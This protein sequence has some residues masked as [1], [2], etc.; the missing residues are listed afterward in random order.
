MKKAASAVLA[1]AMAASLL[2]VPASALTLEEARELLRTNY[3]DTIPEDILNLDSLDK[4]LEALG[5]PYTVYMTAE[6]YEQFLSQ[7]NGDVVVGIGVSISTAYDS[8]F[9]ILSVLP[10]SP[11]L[12]AGLQ[13]G[14]AIMAVDGVELSET[15]DVQGMVAG[16]EGTQ[17]TITVKQ[18]SDGTRKDYVL[19]RRTVPI[20]IC[21]YQKNGNIGYIDCDSFGDATADIITDALEELD[22]EVDV[23]IVDLRSNPGGTVVSATGSSGAF[24]G[25][26][27]TMIYLRDAAGGLQYYYTTDK[28]P[29][30]TDRPVIILTSAYSASGAEV[31]SGDARDYGFGIGVGQ[32]TFGKGIAQTVYEE[33]NRPDLFDGDC[34]KITTDRFFSGNGT[35][36]HLVGVLPTLLISPENTQKAAELLCAAPPENPAGF[37]Q[38]QLAGFTFY[39]DTKEAVKE[40][41]AAAFSELL[42]A[43]PPKA[44]L[45]YSTGTAF[46]STQPSTPDQIASDLKLTFQSRCGFPDLDSSERS[47]KIR[48]LAVY[49]MVRGNEDGTFAPGREITRAEFAAMLAGALDLPVPETAAP[50]SD[51][52]ADSWYAGSVAALYNR[53]FVNGCGDG[54]F[55]PDSPVTFQEVCRTLASVSA[56]VSMDAYDLATGEI[57][58]QETA[59]YTGFAPWARSSAWLLEKLE[60]QLEAADP[61]APASRGTCASM[62][63]DM[64]SA[65]GL[66]WGA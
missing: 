13:P 45:K 66:F 44:V 18:V 33:R 21:T 15:S 35:T 2:A 34:F 10:D 9:Q 25:G 62:I 7:V 59:Q 20:P 50:F 32:R 6:E 23:W 17:V 3:V 16:Q 31:F 5:D 46:E 60:I 64:A 27:K 30:L 39:V 54:T 43:M 52:P 49:G 26:G 12:E 48:T 24:L 65:C 36:N 19:T 63:Y 61:L 57:P 53:G 42:A 22:D 4:I 55:R 40:E 1:L 8:G 37:I 51:V 41:N 11:A 14:D 29:D 47:D 56:W 38:V 28:C 58:E